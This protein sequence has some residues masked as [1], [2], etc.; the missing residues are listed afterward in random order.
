MSAGQQRVIEEN[1]KTIRGLRAE[2]AQA[3][4]DSQV[5]TDLTNLC[6]EYEVAGLKA[7]PVATLRHLRPKKHGVYGGQPLTTA[8]EGDE[9]A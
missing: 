6:D 2:L 9:D 5:F 8:P 4:A 1:H 7:I 3:K